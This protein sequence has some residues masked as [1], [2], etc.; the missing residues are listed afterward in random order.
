MNSEELEILVNNLPMV[1]ESMVYGTPEDD[2]NATI[3]VKVVY[4]KEYIEEKY[5]NISEDEIKNIIWKEIKA[6]NKTMPKYKYIKKLLITDQEFE[7]TTTN[8]IKR[9]VE[10]EKIMQM[11]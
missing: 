4:N 7:K 2:G 1:S 3:S 8:K 6:I 10:T 5:G 11:Q 9:A